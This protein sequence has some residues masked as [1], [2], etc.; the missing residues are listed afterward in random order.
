MEP[1]RTSVKLWHYKTREGDKFYVDDVDIARFSRFV[2]IPKCFMGRYELVRLQKTLLREIYASTGEIIVPRLVVTTVEWEDGKKHYRSWIFEEAMGELEREV[3]GIVDIEARIES[4]I[5]PSSPEY[6]RS[7]LLEIVAPAT[8]RRKLVG[9]F[10]SLGIKVAFITR[11]SDLPAWEVT[12]SGADN[13]DV[14]AYEEPPV[15]M[16]Q[17]VVAWREWDNQIE[18]LTRHLKAC[19]KGHIS[20]CGRE[21]VVRLQKEIGELRQRGEAEVSTLIRQVA[22]RLAEN[23]DAVVFDKAWLFANPKTKRSRSIAILASMLAERGVLVMSLSH[24]PTVSICNNPML[25]A[26]GFM[27]QVARRLD[28]SL[29][30]YNLF[31]EKFPLVDVLM[32]PQEIGET[33][34]KTLAL[35]GRIDRLADIYESLNREFSR[36]RV[37]LLLLEN[38]SFLRGEGIFDADVGRQLARYVSSGE[39]TARIGKV[40]ATV[41]ENLRARI[42]SLVAEKE[43]LSASDVVSVAIQLLEAYPAKRVVIYTSSARTAKRVAEELGNRG[44]SP[45]DLSRLQRK[46]TAGIAVSP[47]IAGSGYPLDNAVGILL[48]FPLYYAPVREVI[49]FY[50]LGNT[51]LIAY[52]SHLLLSLLEYSP[53]KARVTRVPYDGDDEESLQ[54][55]VRWIG[56]GKEGERE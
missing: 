8:F 55:V 43:E 9:A 32:L 28:A 37:A 36:F 51:R 47:V 17:A 4:L 39:G 46:R 25:E 29:S 41:Q 3:N 20:G 2:D 50:G 34:R 1:V 22:T 40:L 52:P 26:G 11:R 15:N 30:F 33:G 42:E 44:V 7:R 14:L 54:A 53:V 12:T 56:A 23:Y 45:L 38:A 13:V 19:F 21:E 31:R 48:G 49:G 16:W 24:A 18:E 35:A 27:H 6:S 10:R 5:H